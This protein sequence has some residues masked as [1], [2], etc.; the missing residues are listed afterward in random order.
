ML[1]DIPP[2]AELA[3]SHKVQLIQVAAELQPRYT[4]GAWI[5]E[6]A[7]AS[8]GESLLQLVAAT[9]GVQPRADVSL[10]G[11]IVGFLATK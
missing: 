3:A 1:P 7:G 2:V 5:C 11:S 8:D 4:D 10:E 6:L 9:L